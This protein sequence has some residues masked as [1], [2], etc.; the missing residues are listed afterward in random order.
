MKNAYVNLRVISEKYC[1]LMRR[2]PLM[3]FCIK[4]SEIRVFL[5]GL[6]IW[7]AF[8]VQVMSLAG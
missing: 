4:F 7:L 3:R 2:A 6:Q 1:P 8:I 5:L